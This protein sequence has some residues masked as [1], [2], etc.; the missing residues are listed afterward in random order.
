MPRGKRREA[1]S[2]PGLGGEDG[3]RLRP[4]PLAVRLRPAVGFAAK[5]RR[6]VM[7]RLPCGAE[8]NEEIDCCIHCPRAEQCIWEAKTSREFYEFFLAVIVH[9]PKTGMET[10]EER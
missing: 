10:E 6:G 1:R 3:V 4:A 5:P 7:I 2:S 9:D 8:A